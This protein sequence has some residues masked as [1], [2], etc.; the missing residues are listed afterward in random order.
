MQNLPEL[1]KYIISD[2]VFQMHYGVIGIRKIL[3]VG[4]LL[5]FNKI[6]RYST[7]STNNWCKLSSSIDRL[8]EGGSISSSLAWSSLVI[9]KYSLWY[10]VTNLN[11]YRQ[12]RNS[13]FCESTRISMRHSCWISH[14]GNRKYSRRLSNSQ[15]LINLNID[16]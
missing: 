15:V 16:Y 11:D 14:L 12:R 4:K 13:T 10:F 2:D 7:Y 8:Y 3:S 5:D 6:K 9:D 1:C